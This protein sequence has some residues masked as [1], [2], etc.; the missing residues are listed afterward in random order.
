VAS[1]SSEGPLTPIRL[2]PV[3]F[4]PAL[5][6]LSGTAA[7]D[8]PL[9]EFECIHDE[10]MC[11]TIAVLADDRPLTR[12]LDVTGIYIYQGVENQMYQAGVAVTPDWPLIYD[13]DAEFRI[14][15]T[16][17]DDWDARDVTGRVY[18]YRSGKLLAAFQ[19]DAFLS[20]SST[21][22]DLEST[23]N[24]RVP[25]SVFIEGVVYQI[26]V[27]E[28][29][30]DYETHESLQGIPTFPIDDYGLLQP[31]DVGET[32]RIFA[33]PIEYN[34]DGSGRLPDTTDLQIDLYEETMWAFY[35]TPD[36]EI[37]VADEP[38]AT[39][40]SVGAMD[41]M[42]WATL[43]IQVADARETYGVDDDQ[44]VYGLFEPADT[45]E[46]FCGGGC[47]MGMSNL[48]TNMSDPYFRSSIGVGYPGISA[49]ETMVHE[50]GHAHG[51]SHSPGC[52]A[53]GAD[54]S[55]PLSTGLVDVVGYDLRDDS[56]RSPDAYYD[57]MS[58]C[59]P[60]WVSGYT[61]D[62]LAERMS[63]LNGTAASG[64]VLAWS[65]LWVLPDGSMRWGRDRAFVGQ[66]SGVPVTVDLVE[67]G[68]IVGE[69][70]AFFSRLGDLDKAGVLSVRTGSWDAVLFRNRTSP[71]RVVPAQ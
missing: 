37:E 19:S 50:V 44:Y 34:A 15:V 28:K 57:F 25:G 56:L 26:E 27:V 4:V 3:P 16:A 10:P 49:A 47:I 48:A 13:R 21:P 45:I 42:G 23:I 12:G 58:Y 51:R 54:P 68:R 67:D 70:E 18:L 9:V 11:Q 5:L 8:A 17:H 33:I 53:D 60:Y 6:A 52:G 43:L 22:Y 14:L 64:T 55:Y 35:P 71:A 61:F 7:C 62:A 20:G 69:T 2:R 40:T 65:T 46:G 36:V 63:L 39:E 1:L 30:P 31:K 38:L 24:V 59:H 29:D 41:T 66:P 32:I